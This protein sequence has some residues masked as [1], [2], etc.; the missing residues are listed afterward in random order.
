MNDIQEIKEKVG[1]VAEEI[2]ARQ[3][4]LQKNGGK[5]RCPDRISHRH[6]DRNPSMSWDPKL[7]QFKCFGCGRLLDIYTLYREYLNYSHAEIVREFLNK[8]YEDTSMVKNRAK[9]N[10]SAKQLTSLDEKQLQ[11]LTTRKLNDVTIKAFKLQSYQG[12]IAFPYYKNE[13]LIGCKTRK[14]QEHTEGSKYLS[15]TGSKPGLFNYDSI[16]TEKSLIICEG[17]IDCMIIY[18]A[19]FQNVVSVGAGANSLTDLIEQ[20]RE[21]LNSLESLIIFSD[22]DEAGDRMDE[23]FLNA[24]PDKIMLID[25]SI[26][27]KK[28]ANEEY[29]V[30]GAD[31]IKKIIE[32]AQEKIEGFFNPDTDDLSLKEVFS[33]GK[34]IP[35]GLPSIDQA[36]NDLAPGCVTLIAGRSNGGKSTFINQV[37][38]NAIEGK[39]K[40]LLISG[41]D[42]KRILVNK[43]YQAVIGRDSSL[44]NYTLI[45]KRTFKE[46]KPDTLKKLKVW[47]KDKLHLFMKGEASLKTT[48]QLFTL[49][50][51]KIKID[52]YN[53]VIIDNLM[54][55]LSVKSAA[56][57]Y[58]A[59]ADFVQR[60][61]DIA[62]IYHTNIC[63]VLHPN[64]TFR[65]GEQMDFEQISGSSDISNKADNI[66]AIIREYDEGKKADGIDGY[67]EILKNRYSSEL[68]KIP[69]HFDIE[70]GL[71]LEFNE[72]S[73]SSIYYRF[74]VVGEETPI[75]NVQVEGSREVM[76][77][78]M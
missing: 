33:R 37:I 2:I 8:D 64:K 27:T 71:L 45:N 39:N 24:F 54:S 34:F 72:F 58:E 18:Q 49:I 57:K 42:D 61:C 67:A 59:Q 65:K 7:L 10:D 9:L 35:T 77:W 25:K 36:L 12:A 69:L 62:K 16:D 21:I 19:G 44:Y 66:I 28:D 70:T 13:V 14:P 29:L 78:D 17:E 43:I 75:D 20:N 22:N 15:L 3:L 1:Q 55:V 30:G 63:I 73:G 4:H 53:L 6:G 76:E 68:I 50:S 38:A 52:K 31:A 26:I 11:Y 5:Y 56:D 60:C 46:P 51:R 47:H 40:V 41:E 23:A 74:N 48:E 32:S